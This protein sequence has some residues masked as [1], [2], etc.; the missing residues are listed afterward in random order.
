MSDKY[1]A[2]RDGP[3][4]HGQIMNL[5]CVQANMEPRGTMARLAYKVGHRDARHAAAELAA[6]QGAVI[7]ALLADLDAAVGALHKVIDHT[8]PEHR[9]A[10]HEDLSEVKSIAIATLSQIKAA[11][12]K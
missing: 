8:P 11:G 2:L 3:D 7:R 5:Q 10:D 1:Q 9:F 4:L 12:S 6:A